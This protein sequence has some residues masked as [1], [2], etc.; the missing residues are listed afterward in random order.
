MPGNRR[1]IQFTSA[2]VKGRLLSVRFGAFR[3]TRH[4]LMIRL[5][6]VCI[7]VLCLLPYVAAEGPAILPPAVAHDT[8]D[9]RQRALT[10]CDMSSS[11]VKTSGSLP[12]SSVSVY[13]NVKAVGDHTENTYKGGRAP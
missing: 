11:E 12:I 7:S 5:F 10:E 2:Q 13:N 1:D 6:V 9:K 8:G 3:P 4:L